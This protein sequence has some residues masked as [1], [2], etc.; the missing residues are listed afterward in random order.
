MRFLHYSD[1]HDP[2]F[3]DLYAT[4]D[5]LICTGDLAFFDLDALRKL[6]RDT[7]KF[8]VHGNH[9]D[10]ARDPDGR[11]RTYMEE[12]GI[13]D[14]HGRVVEWHGLKI[15]GFQGCPRYKPG[16]YQFDEAEAE[17]FAASCEPVDILLLHCGGLGLLDDADPG[18]PVHTG[19]AAIRSYIL[20]TT[21]RLIFV[22]H[23]YS[24]ADARV[25][26]GSIHRAYG[27][28]IVEADPYLPLPPV[29]APPTPPI[30]RYRGDDDDQVAGA[31][32]TGRQT[33]SARRGL[34]SVVRDVLCEPWA[35]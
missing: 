33:H 26:T 32:D 9:D 4:A 22:G 2:A 17:A 11:P 25:G 14:V 34:W 3:G 10:H 31:W 7:P 12:Y 5:V 8:G 1:R 13:E 19:S 30:A 23:Q 15:G 6:P 28:R 20:R 24:L 27:A 29:T 16:S 18:D 35:R 21:P